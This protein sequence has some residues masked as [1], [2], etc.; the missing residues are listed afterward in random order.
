MVA[1][2]EQLEETLTKHVDKLDNVVKIHYSYLYEGNTHIL[3]SDELLYLSKTLYYSIYNLHP[4]LRV[5]VDHLSGVSK[6]FNSLPNP[7]GLTWKTHNGLLINQ[8]Y[9]KFESIY[10]N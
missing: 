8:Y 2:E 1:S 4:N 5:L 3:T 9:I 7:K 6:Q 10:I